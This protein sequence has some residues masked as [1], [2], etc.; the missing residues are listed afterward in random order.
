MVANKDFSNGRNSIL[1]IMF[2]SEFPRLQEQ[3]QRLNSQKAA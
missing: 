1:V 2:R 3:V